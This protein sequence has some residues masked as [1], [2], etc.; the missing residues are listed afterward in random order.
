MTS[1]VQCPS[2]GGRVHSIA[3]RCKH[4][5]ADLLQ[6]REEAAR[7]ARDEQKGLRQTYK[8]A[9]AAP[10]GRAP[11]QPSQPNQP[12]QA[13]APQ[14]VYAQPTGWARRWPIAVS[15]VAVVAIV[16]SLVI[17]LGGNQGEEDGRLPSRSGNTPRMIPDDMNTPQPSGPQGMAPAPADPDPLAPHPFDPPPPK[18]KSWTTAPDPGMFAVALTETVCAKFEDCGLDDPYASDMCRSLAQGMSTPDV[19]AKVQSGECRYDRS[20]ASECL[21]AIDRLSC[22]FANGGDLSD[23]LGQATGLLDCST[24]LVCH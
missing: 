4:C 3:S 6:H 13:R 20:A 7:V 22:N 18:P 9:A 5:K 23:I 14:I 2:C 24:A 17:L 8:G 12:P 10:G 11:T 16:V 15:A 1:F 21:R 19:D